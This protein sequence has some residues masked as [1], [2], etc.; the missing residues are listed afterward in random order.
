MNNAA[1]SAEQGR[2]VDDDGADTAA[3]D[4]MHATNYLGVI[5]LIRAASKVIRDN[6]RIISISS[7]VGTRVGSEILA[8]MVSMTA[9]KRLSDPSEMTA[10]IAFLASP[11]ASYITGATL[12]A[13][14]GFNG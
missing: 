12:T 3:Q 13:N 6:G 9:L 11:A 10:V 4:R 7:G 5:A 2:T 1:I 14:G 8:A